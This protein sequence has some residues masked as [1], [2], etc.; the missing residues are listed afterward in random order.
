V[1]CS[2]CNQRIALGL[3]GLLWLALLKLGV[4][5]TIAGL[6]MGMLVPARPRLEHREFHAIDALQKWLRGDEQRGAGASS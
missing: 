1:L 6:I 5:A 3:G 2:L 4:H